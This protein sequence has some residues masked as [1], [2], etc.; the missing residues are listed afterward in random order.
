[1]V[2]TVTGTLAS[3]VVESGNIDL[4][5]LFLLRA[6]GIN[7]NDKDAF[8]GW[9]AL[10]HALMQKRSDM[11]VLL[12]K[13]LNGW[14]C[15]SGHLQG[16]LD[17]AVLDGT[18]EVFGLLLSKCQLVPLTTIDGPHMNLLDEL[19]VRGDKRMWKVLARYIHVH[20]PS[21]LKK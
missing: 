5:K 18:P 12:L 15:S 6:R 14:K 9:T 10:D 16:N 8:T 1:M 7:P 13:S 20:Y 21:A 17:Y 4:L 2:N 11:A 3:L 19:N